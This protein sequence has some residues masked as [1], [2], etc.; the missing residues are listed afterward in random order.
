MEGRCGV[1]LEPGS[2]V[3]RPY[4]GIQ[5]ALTRG[6]R[7]RMH[8][9]H[10]EDLTRNPT[11]VLAGIYR[12]LDEQPYA[13]DFEHVEQVTFEDDLVHGIKGLHDI[14]PAVRPVPKRAKDVLGALAD[15]YKG[16]YIWDEHLAKDRPK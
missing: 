9:I 3:G 12:F 4:V 10:F 13:H 11:A 16:P 15:K 2:V 5:D 8:F 1:W 7:D 14:R 6:F